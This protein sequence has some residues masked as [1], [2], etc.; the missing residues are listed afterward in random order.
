MLM[1]AAV[2]YELNT[3]LVVEEVELQQPQ[4]GEVLIKVAAS[5][6]CG[7]DLHVINGGIKRTL[8]MV[9]GHECAGVVVETGKGVTKVQPG[10]HVI[11][12][13]VAPCGN[14]AYCI[15]KKPHLCST[16]AARRFTGVMDDGTCRIRKDGRAIHHFMGVS[17]FAEY[18]VVA[19]NAAIPINKSIPF[20]IAALVGCGVMTGIGA[21]INTAK[22]EPG[23]TVAIIGLG[24]V[25]LNVVQGCRLAGAEKIIVIDVLDNKLEGARDFGATHFINARNIDTVQAVRDITAGIGVDY[26]FEVI[27]NPTTALQAFNCTKKGG[28]ALVV[29]IAAA[30]KTANIPLY[31]FP[32]EEKT[33]TGSWY[34]STNPPVDFPK[35]LNLYSAGKLKL[36]ELVSRV[37]S[38]DQINEAF[39]VLQQGDVIRSVIIF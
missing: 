11:V 20:D 38:L 28:M 5:G 22:V 37:F 25:G 7:S 26:A 16:A 32:A 14:C 2:L 3:P 30:D 9:L 33:M 35:I 10:D 39:D 4:E 6:V 29:G 17:S 12:S 23:S 27:G 1:K 18:A 34:G 8:P 15:A 36:D 24:G 19:E 13:W 21:A 31:S